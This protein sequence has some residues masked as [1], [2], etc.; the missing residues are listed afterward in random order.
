MTR[1]VKPGGTM[2]VDDRNGFNEL[3][4]LEMLWTVWH[5]WSVGPRFAFN[6]YMHWAQLILHQP[7]ETQVTVLSQE[8]VT[9]GDPVLMVLHRI[10]L[11]L[12]AEKLRVA[13]TGLLL[14]FYADDA[15][16]DGLSRRSTHLLKLLMKRVLDRGYFLIR[17]IYSLY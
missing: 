3:S 15:A 5:H 14:P 10:T 8:G 9:Q 4:R 1:D 11:I 12:L 17:P 2:L 13:D 7:G 6:S 16:F